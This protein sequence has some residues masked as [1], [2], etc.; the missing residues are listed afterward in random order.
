MRYGH[1]MSSR[2]DPQALQFEGTQPWYERNLFW[3]TTGA[4]LAFG[5]TGVGFGMSGHPTL[6][7]WL[8]LGA[9]PCGTIAIWC[10]LDSLGFKKWARLSGKVGAA[11]IV[12][13]AL[14]AIGLRLANVETHKSVPPSQPKTQ[15]PSQLSIQ[16]N[17]QGNASPAVGNAQGN[18]NIT[19]TQEGTKKSGTKNTGD[20]KKQ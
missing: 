12:G 17:T 11:V 7:R 13:L 14:G 15:L 1:D 4:C 9:W 19:I 3:G 16:Q 8:L 5:L 6:A 20:E 10:L 2:A 18:V